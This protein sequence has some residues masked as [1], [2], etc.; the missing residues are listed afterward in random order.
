MK[1]LNLKFLVIFFGLSSSLAFAE[2]NWKKDHIGSIDYY[3]YTPSNPKNQKQALMVNLHGCTQK[4]ETLQKSGNWQ[5]TAD[6]Y[7]MVVVVP[8]VPNGG[9]ILGCWD[10]YGL[11]HTVDNRHNKELISLI[12]SISNSSELNVDKKAIYISGLSSG[13]GEALVISCL[14]PDLIA[15]VGLSSTPALGTDSSET[16]SVPSSTAEE[17]KNQ[18]A[19]LAGK[20]QK[21]L[22][23]QLAVIITGD[24]DFVLNTSHSR[25]NRDMYKE[26]HQLV[27]DEAIDTKKLPGTRTDGEA[28]VFK[29]EEQQAFLTYIVNNQLGHNW[30]AG[31]GA[32]SSQFVS[33]SSVNFP[34]YITSFFT[35][36]SLR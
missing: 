16:H 17:M 22:Q 35:E 33:G 23:T 9:V 21:S 32:V 6:K 20:Y 30:P 24:Q 1:Q 4:S 31:S 7:N 2:G 25:A 10:Y 36:N 12:E 15:G 29:N 14:R 19:K 5:A 26:M 34:E 28:S 11:D 8:Q 3:L 27:V 18:C 13:G